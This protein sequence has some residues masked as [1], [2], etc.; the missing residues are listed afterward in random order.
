MYEYW[1]FILESGITVIVNW[2]VDYQET[3]WFDTSTIH[4]PIDDN[5]FLHCDWIN[6]PVHSIQYGQYRQ[7]ISFMW[8][9]ATQIPPT[10]SDCRRLGLCWSEMST[11]AWYK[12]FAISSSKESILLTCKGSIGLERPCPGNPTP[13][14]AFPYYVS[15]K[16]LLSL[17][18][19]V[20]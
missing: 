6:Y 20:A 4:K 7:V 15:Y 5:D 13:V 9:F 17:D 8:I 19:A 11:I 16:C 10:D 1:K 14:V 3:K 12:W 18:I 2:N